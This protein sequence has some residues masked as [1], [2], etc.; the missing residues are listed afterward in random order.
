MEK[1]VGSHCIDNLEK[2]LASSILYINA[3]PAILGID[4]ISVK[5]VYDEPCIHQEATYEKV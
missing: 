3:K 1:I 5:D 2:I 4:E